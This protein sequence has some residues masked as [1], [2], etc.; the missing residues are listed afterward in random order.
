MALTCVTRLV[1]KTPKSRYCITVLF[2]GLCI[3]VD[4]NAQKGYSL[5]FAPRTIDIY[6]MTSISNLAWRHHRRLVQHRLKPCSKA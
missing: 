6:E 4:V 5:T 3:G 1:A 2:D